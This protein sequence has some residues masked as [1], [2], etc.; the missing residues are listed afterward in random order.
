MSPR[1]VPSQPAWQAGDTSGHRGARAERFGQH[2][3]VGQSESQ[4]IRPAD[5]LGL[6]GPDLGERVSEL[7]PE[8]AARPLAHFVAE[9]LQDQVTDREGRAI[10]LRRRPARQV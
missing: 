8:I 3:E 2:L 1:Y 4:G 6:V 7:P 9:D 5:R 10:T